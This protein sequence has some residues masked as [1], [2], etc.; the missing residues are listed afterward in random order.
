MIKKSAILIIGVLAFGFNIKE[1]V[2]CKNVKNLTPINPTTEFNIKDKRAYAFAYLTDIKENKKIDFVWEKKV[3]DKWKIYSDVKLQIKKGK[4]WRTY[5]S[6][7]ID[8]PY[9]KGEWRVSLYDK[10]LSLKTI[11]FKIK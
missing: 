4:R 11:N 5:S 8:K 7:R 1:F 6:I 9:F 10:N 3:K 2:T